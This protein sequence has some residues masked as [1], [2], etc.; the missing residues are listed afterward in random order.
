MIDPNKNKYE[1]KVIPTLITLCTVIAL[2]AIYATIDMQL[3]L[4]TCISVMIYITGYVHG[5]EANDKNNNAAR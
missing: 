2:L 1:I 5:K 4:L 3:F